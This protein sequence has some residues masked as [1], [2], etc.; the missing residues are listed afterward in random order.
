MAAEQQEYEL[1]QPESRQDR[2]L[3]SFFPYLTDGQPPARPRLLGHAARPLR[4]PAPGSPSP[5][6]LRLRRRSVVA[7]DGPW[8]ELTL[9]FSRTSMFPFFDIAHYLVS[10][11]ALKHQPGEC[12]APRTG[13]L[14]MPL[15][16][17]TA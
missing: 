11:M 7:M 6:L 3:E 14:G 4:A 2:P 16:A 5:R 9:A 10:V 15:T 17:R 8:N 12:G 13:P 1:R